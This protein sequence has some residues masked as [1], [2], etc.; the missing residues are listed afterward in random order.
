MAAEGIAMQVFRDMIPTAGDPVPTICMYP[1]DPP[2]VQHVPRV[3]IGKKDQ[4]W[5]PMIGT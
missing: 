1:G 5:K 4:Y 2:A 3:F